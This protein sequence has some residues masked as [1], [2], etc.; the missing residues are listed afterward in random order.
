MRVGLVGHRLVP[1]FLSDDAEWA[2][3]DSDIP[4]NRA[5]PALRVGTQAGTQRPQ[6][7]ACGRPSRG[8]V[9]SARCPR[10][11][12]PSRRV[13]PGTASAAAAPS[14]GNPGAVAVG[15]LVRGRTLSSCCGAAR[16]SCCAAP[17]T[18]GIQLSRRFTQISL[19]GFSLKGASSRLP[20]RISMSTSPGLLVSSSR[21]PQRGQ[22]PRHCHSLRSCRSIPQTPRRPVNIHSEN[23]LP[24]SFSAIRAVAT[25]DMHR[26]T[27]N[28]VADRSAETSAGANSCLHARGCYARLRCASVAGNGGGEARAWL[29]D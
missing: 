13:R 1:A 9:S 5:L 22:K 21:D 18:G 12:Q 28:A 10:R 23:V 4:A 8:V 24:D 7:R 25:P 15:H 16:S 3:L 6:I 20:I 17:S 11:I 2:R 19:S 14:T 26:V 27:A 29:Q